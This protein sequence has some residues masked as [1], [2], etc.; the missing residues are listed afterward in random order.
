MIPGVDP[1]QM[2]QMMRQ[3]GMSQEEIKA[4]RVIIET[5]SQN[6]IFENPSVMK[7]KMKGEETFQL[8]GS[9]N[10]EDAKLEVKI[11]EDD[12]EMVCAQANVSKD[13]AK[14]ALETSNGDIAEA[15]VGLTQE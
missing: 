6:F 9:Y 5:E 1:R 3:M 4:T 7:I 15:I 10:L 8:S 14:K 2:K 13:E 12:I 11:S